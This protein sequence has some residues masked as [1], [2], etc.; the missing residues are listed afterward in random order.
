MFNDRFSRK[1]SGRFRRI[2]LLLLAAV[3]GAAVAIVSAEDADPVP[4]HK[5]GYELIWQDEFDGEAIDP[6][7][8]T[9]DIGAGGWG[10]GEAQYYTDRSEN[11]SVQD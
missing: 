5:E 10:N 2:I 1:G 8:W 3:L 4:V 7:N 11:A 6:A 9:F